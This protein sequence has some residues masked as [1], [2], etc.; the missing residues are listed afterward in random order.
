[1]N[2][3]YCFQSEWLKKKRSLASWLI[4]LTALFMPALVFITRVFSPDRLYAE[5]LSKHFWEMIYFRNWAAMG[6]FLLPLSL[7][8]STSLFANLEFKNNTWKQL[9]TTPQQFSTLF[10]ARLSVILVMLVQLFVVFNIGIY[11]SALAPALV[12]KGIQFPKEIFPFVSYMKGK[13]EV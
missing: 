8:L 2:F 13:S 1:M 5:N 7:I 9:H 6:M 4:V 3:V 11:L 12:Y 10:L